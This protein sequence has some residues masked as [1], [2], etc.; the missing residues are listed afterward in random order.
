MMSPLKT[1]WVKSRKG[2][3]WPY[4]IPV[5]WIIWGRETSLGFVGTVTYL[6]G[7]CGS[8]WCHSGRL[9]RTIGGIRRREGQNLHPLSYPMLRLLMECLTLKVK[10]FWNV[11]TA[12]TLT[13]C[14]IQDDGKLRARIMTECDSQVALL[15][16]VPDVFA[17][18]A[19]LQPVWYRKWVLMFCWPCISV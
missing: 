19:L 14:R 8:P 17:M 10:Q 12:C 11:G 18:S 6:P 13:R 2:F 16:R 4:W 1:V 3:L 9:K 5:R 15:F 7:W